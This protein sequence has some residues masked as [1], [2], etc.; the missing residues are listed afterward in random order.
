MSRLVARIKIL[1]AE[2]D[3]D[4]N[5]LVNTLNDQIPKGMELKTHMTEPIAFGVNAILGDFLIDDEEGQMDKLEESIKN[6]E[7]V[8]EIDVVSV[9]R[10]SVKMK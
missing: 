8:G 4:L 1:P 7:G 6:T 5:R 2:A 9:S 10:Q 3:T